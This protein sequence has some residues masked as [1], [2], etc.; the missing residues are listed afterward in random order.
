MSNKKPQKLL[1]L[2]ALLS[3]AKV[4]AFSQEETRSETYV[5]EDGSIGISTRTPDGNYEYQHIPAAPPPPPPQAAQPKPAEGQANGQTAVQPANANAAAP[6]AGGRSGA[7]G[8]PNGP[9]GA[10]PPVPNAGDVQPESAP[11]AGVRMAPRGGFNR[12]QMRPEA[13]RGERL[14][15][16]MQGPFFFAD[17]TASQVIQALEELMGK[18]ILIAQ[19]LPV[20]KINF[21]SKNQMTRE[22]AIKALKSLL[23][24][25]GVAI[26]Q[27]DDKTYRAVPVVGITRRSPEFIS[28]DVSEMEPS[29]VF[30]TKLFELEYIDVATT[31]PKIRNLMSVDGQGYIENFPRSNAILITDTLVNIQ[32]VDKVLKALDVPVK[33]NEEMGFIKLTNIG[34][35]DARDKITKLQ[36]DLLKKYLDKTTFEVDTRTNQL[37][38]VTQKGNLEIIEKIIKGIDLPAE[39][40][41][42][43]E[44]LFIRYSEAS[45]MESVLKNI[46]TQ[47]RQI[48][49]QNARNRREDASAAARN[50][51]VQANAMRNANPN[52]AVNLQLGAAGGGAD[53]TGTELS[54]YA[55]VA[56]YKQSSAIVIYGTSTDIAQLRRIVKRLDVP[57]DQVKIDVI[58]TEVTLNEGQVSGLSSFGISYNLPDATS[59]MGLE[60]AFALATGSDSLD[61]GSQA[62]SFGINGDSFTAAFNKAR[63][64]SNIKVLSSPTIVTTHNQEG[65]VT[66]DEQHP[67]VTGSTTDLDSTATRQ[68]VSYMD[69]GINLQV[70]PLVGTDGIVRMDITQE[71]KSVARYVEIDNN[72]TPVVSNRRIKNIVS[73]KTGEVIVLG[74]LQQEDIANV[75]SGVWLLSDIPWIGELFKPALKTTKRRELIMFVRPS[76]IK[77]QTYEQL[78][79]SEAI[80]DSAISR[81]IENY[82]SKGKFFQKEEIDAN[83]KEFEENRF[84]NRIVK[85]PDDFIMLDKHVEEGSTKDIEAKRA[86]QKKLN[87]QVNL[88]SQNEKILKIIEEEEAARAKELKKDEPLTENIDAAQAAEAAA[89]AE[90]TAAQDASKNE[91]KPKDD[92]SNITS[93]DAETANK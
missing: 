83:F 69:I 56:S 57:V 85:N 63:E 49:Q 76:V 22:D 8:R 72:Q 53:G 14:P 2:F 32:R 54:E 4:L 46:I 34:P 52:A 19:G 91:T 7:S 81:E 24:L 13:P 87:E 16:D 15:D 36:G 37:I 38:V 21:I 74:G 45:E 42:K 86:Q 78:I 67:Y 48:Q 10:P 71:V 5:H 35:S 92:A 90:R 23:T 39:A 82:L 44:V 58:I 6:A 62:F 29:E 73:V 70:K 77:S 27:L 33:M 93:I 18:T 40:L 80:Q 88:E 17:E 41:L 47:Q 60:N 30:Y 50:A 31:Q 55:Q 26:S 65:Q 68:S 20:T 51:A 1:A 28:G 75:D 25:N 89:E 12:P 43:E 79:S 9:A 66:V 59:G 84:H 11:D 3:L 64:S 61:A